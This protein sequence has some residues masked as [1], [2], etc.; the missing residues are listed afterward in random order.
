[1]AIEL[2][3]RQRTAVESIDGPLLVLAGAG[4]GKTGVITNRIAHMLGCGIAGG[5]ILGVT[6]TNK[7]A[8]EMRGRLNSLIGVESAAE[9]TLGTF[10]SFCLRLL[11]REIRHFPG[12]D[13]HFTIAGDADQQGIVKQVYGELNLA[14]DEFKHDRLLWLIGSWKNRAVDCLGAMEEAAGTFES[15][16][17]EV[18]QRYQ[19]ILENQNMLDFDDLL[20]F[21]LRLFEENPEVLDKYRG[22]YR[23]V[24]V[25]EYQ[26]TNLIQF[27]II[28]K[29]VDEHR[30]ICV[31]GDDD[32]S[33]YGWRGAR[34]SNILD[35]PVHFPGARVIKLEQNYRSTNAVLNMAN[36]VIGGGGRRFGKKLW[37][38]NGDG[39][40]PA[41]VKC[42]NETAEAGFVAERIRGIKLEEDCSY[43]DFVVLYRSN[44]LS[45]QIENAMRES[46]IPYR[47]VGSKSFFQRKEIIDSVAYLKLA[48]NPRDDQSLLRI[49]GVPPRGIGDKAVTTLKNIRQARPEPYSELMKSPEFLSCVGSTARSGVK[50]FVPAFDAARQ[51]F[52]KGGDLAAKVRAYLAEIGFINGL[53]R[54]Y[55]NRDEA[56]GRRENVF[57]FINTIAMFEQRNPSITLDEFLD[58]FSLLDDGDKEDDASGGAAAVT[59]MTIHA[60]KGLEFDN[61]FVVGLEE[62]LLPNERALKEGAADEERRLLY[63]A[64]TRARRRLFLSHAATRFRYGKQERQTRSSFLDG[65]SADSVDHFVPEDFHKIASDDDIAAG[66]EA[67]LAML[68]KK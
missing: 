54:I 45:R 27:L 18:Y 35:F 9:V 67:I 7:A 28:K 36:Q 56:D 17:A 5:E 4:T 40:N 22:I 38:E 8:R 42:P 3:A 68:E 12:F 59:L 20:L 52:E 24:L 47:V 6:F 60:A 49:I 19:K 15:V 37:S 61:V 48:A 66:F 62:G 13:H 31:V 39:E 65:I 33:I 30:N 25:D 46:D 32:Q 63:V 29:L 64:A 44:H 14:K 21:V 34:I 2:N 50:D 11:K 58:S 16:A 55:K 23:R 43:D 57:E 10:H 41:I 1:M 26:D 51:R 53:M